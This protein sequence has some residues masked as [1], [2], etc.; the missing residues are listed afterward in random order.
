MWKPWV[1]LIL[2]V[3]FI[4]RCL[5]SGVTTYRFIAVVW[6]ALWFGLAIYNARSGGRVLRW[7]HSN[8]R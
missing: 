1:P 2:L 7:I 4:Y 5:S 3:Y 8:T 6:M